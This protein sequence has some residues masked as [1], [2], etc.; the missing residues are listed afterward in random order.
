LVK[1]GLVVMRRLTIDF[2]VGAL[3]VIVDVFIDVV[4]FERQAVPVRLRVWTY[5]L[6]PPV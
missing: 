6:R 5:I 2:A 1:G 3:A 4:R